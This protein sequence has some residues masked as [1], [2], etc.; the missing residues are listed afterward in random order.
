MA[1]FGTGRRSWFTESKHNQVVNPTLVQKDCGLNLTEPIKA[2]S[3]FAHQRRRRIRRN[4]GQGNEA[5]GAASDARQICLNI[6][7][8]H[9]PLSAVLLPPP[10]ETDNS[11]LGPGK[12]QVRETGCKDSYSQKS[13]PKCEEVLS[14]SLCDRVTLKV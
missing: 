8:S 3:F 6:T 9:A 7:C 14:A 2:T 5:G 1:L 10:S 4:G 13:M 12:W 11:R